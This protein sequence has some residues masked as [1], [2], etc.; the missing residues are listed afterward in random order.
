MKIKDTRHHSATC[1]EDQADM[2]LDELAKKAF[3]QATFNPGCCRLRCN[4]TEHYHAKPGAL[5]EKLPEEDRDSL[6]NLKSESSY[7]DTIRDFASKGADI[8]QIIKDMS[9][10]PSAIIKDKEDV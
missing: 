9:G 8:P 4:N 6:K 5:I 1:I 3:M 7:R 10:V 2:L